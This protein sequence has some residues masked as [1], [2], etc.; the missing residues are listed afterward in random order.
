MPLTNHSEPLHITHRLVCLTCYDIAHVKH[1]TSQPWPKLWLSSCCFHFPETIFARPRLEFLPQLEDHL[2]TKT[3]APESTCLLSFLLHTS[4]TPKFS[5]V[6]M[7]KGLGMILTYIR[8][9]IDGRNEMSESRRSQQSSLR[10]ILLWNTLKHTEMWWE[11]LEISEFREGRGYISQW[12][13]LRWD[14][15]LWSRE[16]LSLVLACIM[17]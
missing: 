2:F 16:D 17:L 14:K 9:T 1:R 5:F 11:I 12:F 6:F 3:K 4:V 13:S 15:F 10:T 8:V 7:C